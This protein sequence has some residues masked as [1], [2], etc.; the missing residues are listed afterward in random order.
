MTVSCT[1]SSSLSEAIFAAWQPEYAGRG[2]PTF[3][4]R[5]A[6]P[7]KIPITRGY[8]RTGLRGSA[9]LTKRFGNALAMG[10]TLNSRRM[11]VDV[12]TKSERTLADVLAKHGD[13]PLIARTASKGGF[14]CYFGEN[15]GAWKHYKQ[16]RRVIRPESDKPVDYLGAGFAVVPPS[17][18]ATG[19]YEF[20]RGSL[21]DINRLPPFRGV[22]PPLQPEPKEDLTKRHVAAVSQGS[23]NSALFRACM[24]RAHSCASLDQLLAFAQAINA[25][26]IP[27]MDEAEVVEIAKN[28]WR[29]TERGQN[30]FGQHGAYFPTEE[31]TVLQRDPDAFLLL[32]YLRAHNRPTAQFMVSNGLSENLGWTRK[33]LAAARRRL[34]D[35][36]YIQQIRASSQHRPALFQWS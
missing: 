34:I 10:I 23:R 25:Y 7:D 32:G 21:D 19:R 35:L 8:Q 22:V 15:A 17:L 14:H 5:I 4:V 3:P 12:D 2:L 1:V 18:T 9:E 6:G 26:Y 31:I 36:G 20:I 11:V 29:Y 30:R 28:A 33:R 13:T 16:S 27:P 24:K